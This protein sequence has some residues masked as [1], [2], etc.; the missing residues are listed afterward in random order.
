MS[1]ARRSPYARA[2]GIPGALA[3]SGAGLVAR[4]PISM[5]GLGIVVLV[6]S[7]TGSWSRGGVLSAVYLTANALSAIPLA[8]LVDRRGQGRVLGLAATVSALALT[9]LVVTVLSGTPSPVPHLCAVVAGLTQPNVGGA[10]RARWS[11]VTPDRATLDTAFALEAVNDEV[12]F[13]VGPTLTTLL[14][15]AVHPA[16]GLATAAT[17]AVLGGW[18]LV[19]QRATE[20]PV[21]PRGALAAPVAPMPWGQLG[22]LLACAFLLGVLFGGSEVATVAFA[23]AADRPALGGVL[24]ALWAAGSLVAGLVAGA[25]PVRRSA[26][27]RLGA[28]Y[29]V[30]ASLMVPL[31]FVDGMVALG[32]VLLLAGMA[33]SPTLIAAVS[34]VE[35]LVPAGRL[36]D[37]LA[38]FS[39]GLVVGLAP[40]A[41]LTGTV[42]DE[43]GASASYWV[44]VLAG[45]TGAAVASAAALAASR[46]A[47]RVS[48]GPAAR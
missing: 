40:G 12:V 15:S 21:T 8:R 14:A 25:L 9:G 45:L 47:P 19:L 10:V 29:V 6:A 22:T 37:G 41:A 18:W 30:L 27:T 32:C 34:W 1:S 42:I 4:L 33:I 5:T 46:G 20:P 43:Y 23:D 38:V 13:I 16:A 44:P 48:A 36:N 28:G 31:P 24:L 11:H 17:A 35:G 26:V 2:L 7:T 3:F 39:T